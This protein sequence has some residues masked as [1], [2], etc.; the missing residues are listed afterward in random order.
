M[1]KLYCRRVIY[2]YPNTIITLI[3]DKILIF[4]LGK[5]NL[6]LFDDAG[7]KSMDWFLYD[8]ALRHERGN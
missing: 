6:E 8:N 1:G 4:F 7:R 2:Q 5:K 3:E